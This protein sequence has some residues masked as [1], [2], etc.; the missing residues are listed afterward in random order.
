MKSQKADCHERRH[1]SVNP[2]VVVVL[3]GVFGDAVASDRFRVEPMA[4]P[5]AEE[6]LTPFLAGSPGGLHLSWLEKTGDGHRLRYARW[7]GA[8]FTEPSTIRTSN[9]F[10]A[11]WADFSSVLP[12]GEG[13]LA[14]HWLEKSAGGT[15][16]Y[17]VFVA[18]SDDGGKTWGPGKKLHRDEA[19]SEHGFVSLA[20][21]G[22]GFRA[23]W[24]D[25]R[26]FKKD[27]ADNEM[28]LMSTGFDGT[29]FVEETPL[30]SRVC[31]CCQT[32]MA[33]IEGGFLVAYRDRSP[34][35]IRDIGIVR[36][37]SGRWSEP[38]TV[39]GDGWRLTGCP[40]NGP[41][42]AADGNHLALAWFTASRDDPRV[43]VIFSEDGGE[44]FGAPVRVDS[45]QALGRVDVELLGR[46]AVVTWLA[47]ATRGGE[48]L[49]RRISPSVGASESVTVARTG[50]DRASGFPRTASYQ[51]TIYVAWT[52]NSSRQ[53]PSL[54]RL[55]RL[56]LE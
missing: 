24:L 9:R 8:K 40:V 6:S 46:D 4:S 11:N 38:R 41:Q 53:G 50:A 5:A 54:V 32:A 42:V 51:G 16:E 30:D 17:D 20:R 18:I 29:A 15:Y 52:E 56:V 45:G 26:S 1:Y 23:V 47:R 55:A 36:F 37:A 43:Q 19:L 48:I 44:T 2:W 34:D 25:G 12:F 35:E 33:A 27:A 28:A 31:E 13:R 21:E 7:D 22:G 3:L 10:F 49:A 14:A 39:V